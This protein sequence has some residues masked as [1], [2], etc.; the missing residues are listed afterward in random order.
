MPGWRWVFIIEGVVPIFAGFATLFF[1]PNR[2]ENA[3]WLPPEERD[4]CRRLWAI[5]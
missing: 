2:P 1:L 4:A 3:K 5:F